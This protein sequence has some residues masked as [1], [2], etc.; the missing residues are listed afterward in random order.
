MRD[1]FDCTPKIFDYVVAS[2]IFYLRQ[3]QPMRYL[4]DTVAAMFQKANRAIALN[5]LSSWTQQQDTS[6]FYADPLA[7]IQACRKLSQSVVL[8][9]DYHSRDF[10]VYLYKS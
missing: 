7:L 3:H 5:S 10:T 6:E 1:V 9:H 8:R 4:L 2:G